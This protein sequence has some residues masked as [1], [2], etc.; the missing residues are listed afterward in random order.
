MDTKIAF[1][2]V[3]TGGLDP[4]RSALLQ[5]SGVIDIN[6]EEVERFNYF[7]RPFEN[8]EVNPKALQV[9]KFTLEQIQGFDS[10]AKVFGNFEAMLSKYVDR[11]S[12]YDKLFFIGYNSHAFDTQFVR[13]F[14]QKNGSKFYGSYFWAA[15]PDVMLSWSAE[16]MSVR[17]TMKNFKLMTVARKAGIVIDETRL[18]DAMY[19]IE[20]TRELYYRLQTN[21]FLR[22]Q[23]AQEEGALN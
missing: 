20:L 17:H 7:I 12:K 16:L 6:G 23:V 19:D 13:N 21:I 8:D 22:S 5:L 3:E 18:H 2:D 11:F 4:Q 15:S 10:P 9:N 14:F 1:I